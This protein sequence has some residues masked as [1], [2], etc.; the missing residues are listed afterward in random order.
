MS[1][2]K[3]KFVLLALMCALP[4]AFASSGCSGTAF[5]G[6]SDASAGTASAGTSSSAGM[7]SGASSGTGTGGG[8]ATLCNGPEDCD[9]KNVCTLDRCNPDGTCA[10]SPKCSGSDKCCSGECAQ[11]CVDADCD[12]GVSCTTNTCFAGQC[13]FVPNDTACTTSEYCAI[14]DDCQ[15][16]KACTGLANEAASV[17]DDGAACTADS[18]VDNFCQHEFCKD[19]A[20][21]LCCEGIGCAA[22][23]NDSQCD[24]DKDPCTVGSC[25]GGKCSVVPL[26]GKDQQCCPS[27]DGLSATCGSCCNAIDCDDHIGCTVDQCGGGTCSNTPSAELCGGAGYLC[28]VEKRTCVKAPDCTVSSDCKPPTACHSNGTCKEGSCLFDECPVGTTCC[29][30]GNGCGACC[31]DAECNDNI[32]CTKDVCGTTGCTHT[33]DNSVCGRG[34]VCNPTKGCA[35]TCS[36]DADCQRLVTTAAIGLPSSCTTSKCVKGQCVDS[37]LLCASGLTCC[38]ATGT[39]T[40]PA[41]CLQTQ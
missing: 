27:A 5:T 38:A 35:L 18:C 25:E 39:C 12:D 16:R 22:C 8:A 26:C 10:A 20:A 41:K 13:M 9:D 33:A 1:F 19:P 14:K 24:T 31:G 40:L 11:C 29:A 21:K 6:S 28:D 23:C 30:N 2:F 17:C 36:A 3:P 15:P 4:P 7:S 32:D 34:Q 37:T